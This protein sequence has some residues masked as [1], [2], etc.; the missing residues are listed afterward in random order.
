MLSRTVF[1]DFN[2]QKSIYFCN[3]LCGQGISARRLEGPGRALTAERMCL[4]VSEKALLS[5][6]GHSRKRLDLTGQR[7]GSLTVLRPAENN[8]GRTTWLCRCGCG[9]EITV[10]T[11]RLRSGQVTCC[12]RCRGEFGLQ[13]LTY[14]DGTCVEMLQNK[15][16]RRNN[17]C[18]VTGV[19][20][21]TAKHLWRASICFKGRRYYLGSFKQFED[22]VSARKRAEAE[23]HDRFL[24]EYSKAAHAPQS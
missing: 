22:A 10:K 14:V 17:S 21:L 13:T 23:L 18:G 1:K 8:G 20:W 2:L 4:N 6:G 9:E 12:H 24:C 7:F 5:G 11:Y 15:S 16:V 19:D 3:P